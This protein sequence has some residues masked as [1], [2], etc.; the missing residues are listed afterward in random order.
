MSITPD[1]IQAAADREDEFHPESLAGKP[2]TAWQRRAATTKALVDAAN[3][4]A[5]RLAA[6]EAR[7]VSVPFPA[8]SSHG[9]S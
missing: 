3:E 9:G 2:I 1:G 5:A 7:P 8:A 4:H 6:L